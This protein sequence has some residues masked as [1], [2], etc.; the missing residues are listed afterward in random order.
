MIFA[1]FFS[2]FLAKLYHHFA[3]VG[4]AFDFVRVLDRSSPAASGTN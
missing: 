1:S 3:V 2:D 4:S